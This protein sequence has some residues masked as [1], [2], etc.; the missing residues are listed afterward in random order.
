[1][2]DWLIGSL[3]WPLLSP[4]LEC[5]ELLTK[6]GVDYLFWVLTKRGRMLT[7]RENDDYEER[8]LNNTYFNPHFYDVMLNSP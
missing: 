3:P 6:T 4:S 1:M 7:F 8:S 5:D 2:V